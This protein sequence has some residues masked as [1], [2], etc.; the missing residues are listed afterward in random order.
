MARADL[1]G[2]ALEYAEQ[3]K[4]KRPRGPLYR[5]SKED[6]RAGSACCRGSSP[7]ALVSPCGALPA[8]G[9]QTALVLGYPGHSTL[10]SSE[11]DLVF[12]SFR[13]A[14]LFQVPLQRPAK[15]CPLRPPPPTPVKLGLSN[16]GRLPWFYPL[17]RGSRLTI[18]YNCCGHDDK[19][20][21]RGRRGARGTYQESS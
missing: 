6:A 12:L 7:V 21:P 13:A 18:D 14:S 20:F 15:F 2:E 9:T 17:A 8:A 11:L 3:E 10:P 4:E 1:A 16:T 19:R 5:A